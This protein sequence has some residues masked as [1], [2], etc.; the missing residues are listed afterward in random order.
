MSKPGQWKD[1]LEAHT[2]STT[3]WHAMFS[4]NTKIGTYDYVKK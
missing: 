1:E 4:L 3:N 2:T